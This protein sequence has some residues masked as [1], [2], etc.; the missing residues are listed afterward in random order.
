V[1]KAIFILLLLASSAFAATEFGSYWTRPAAPP[2]PDVPWARGNLSHT[3]NAIRRSVIVWP[4]TTFTPSTPDV[5][6][7]QARFP[8][9]PRQ[10]YHATLIEPALHTPHLHAIEIGNEPDLNFTTDTPDRIA[11][12]QKAVAW[13]IRRHRPDLTLLMPSMAAL[14]GPWLEQWQHNRGLAHTDALNVHFY[15]WPH[16]LLPTLAAHRRFLHQS[17][18]PNLPLWITEYGVADV[19]ANPDPIHLARQ[20]AAFERMTLEGTLAG[21][22]QLW[23]FSLTH[24]SEGATDFGLSHPDHSPRPALHA[25]LRIL[26]RSRQYRPIQRLHH[27]AS[28]ETIGWV[29]ESPDRTHWWTMLFSPWR[30]ADLI[31]PPHP[32]PRSVPA[33]ET[34]LQE[35]RLRF[36]KS[37]LPFSLGL[38]GEHPPPR[39]A[40]WSF[41]LS[42]ATNLHFLT[43]PHPCHIDGVQRRPHRNPSRTHRTPTRSN[44]K[45]SPVIASLNL[46]DL[47]V[48]DTRLGYA[49]S[50]G[51][52]IRLTAALHEFSG[53]PRSGRW[54]LAT[55]RN[56]SGKSSGRIQLHPD[57]DLELAIEITPDNSTQPQPRILALDWFGDD[58]SRDTARVELR[59]VTSPSGA[60]EPLDGNWSST[61]PGQRW[62]RVDDR[63]ELVAGTPTAAAHLLLPL[64]RRLTPDTRIRIE[65]ASDNHP[66]TR[67]IEL[68][69]PRRTVFRHGDDSRIG[70]DPHIIEVRIGDFTPAFWSR[71]GSIAPEQARFLHLTLQPFPVGSTLRLH[72]AIQRP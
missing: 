59:P 68:I 27:R 9:N 58:G 52:P 43:P 50:P 16:D 4:G 10:T 53:Q 63:F 49:Y 69:T 57:S 72:S 40:D 11:A 37:A 44:R 31:L 13:A 56:W 67:R 41:T 71:P 3:T 19:P 28:D 65:L 20:R 25:W 38:D 32:G 48:L 66:F 17:D 29:M 45:P 35:I 55:P 61:E 39:E 24:Y 62:E 46:P 23:A 22:Q 12:S 70:P 18:H 21:V 8:S 26:E 5:P 15:G 51:S 30:R 42:A 2:H 36:P 1:A 6:R 34:S 14:P 54:H 7:R 60:W 47:P 33:S 64:P